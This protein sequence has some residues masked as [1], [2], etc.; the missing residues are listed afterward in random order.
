MIQDGV[1]EIFIL[2][3]GKEVLIERLMRGSILNYRTFFLNQPSDV[4]AR[5]TNNVILFEITFEKLLSF[6]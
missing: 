2:I 4:F 5:A 3:D 6:S 1:V